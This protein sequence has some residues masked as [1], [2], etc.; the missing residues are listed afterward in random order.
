MEI[1]PINSEEWELVGR[2][3]LMKYFN[4]GGLSNGDTS[5]L[6]EG[7]NFINT[8]GYSLSLVPNVDLKNWTAD[9]FRLARDGCLYFYEGKN[10]E[11]IEHIVAKLQQEASGSREVFVTILPVSFFYSDSLFTLPLFRFKPSHDEKEEKFIDHTGRV[12]QNIEDWKMNNTL[13]AT[14][15]LYPRDGHLKLKPNEKNKLDVAFEDSAECNRPV[16]TLMACDIASGALGLAAGIGVTLATGGTA[17]LMMG[18]M[19]LSASYGVGRAGFRLRDRASH[20]ESI[21]PFKNRE[22]FWVWLG[23]GSE[24][25]TFGTIGLASTKI[26]SSITQSAAIVEITKR[27]AT[28]SRVMSV[29]SGAARPV[30]DSAKALLTGY[31]IFT[32]FRHK[33]TNAVL[34]LPKSALMQLSESIDEFN[35]TN[36]LMMSIT[37]GFWSKSKIMYVSPEEFQT[38][39]QATIINHMGDNCK[40]RKLFDELVAML[41]ND[42]ALIKTYKNLNENIDLNEMIQVIY[43]VFKANDDKLNIKLLGDTCHISL[44]NFLLHIKSLVNMTQEKIF[45]IIEFLKKF[46]HDQKA[47]FLTI[48]DYIGSNDDFLS[49]LAHDNANE[50]IEIWYDV[51]VICFDEHLTTIP[52]D[53]VIS[54]KN[55]EISIDILKCFNKEERLNLIFTIKNMSEAQNQNFK[56][57]VETDENN[58]LKYYKLLLEDNDFLRK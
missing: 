18:G 11:P 19:A 26:L 38:M 20:S 15:I 44:D 29:F 24:I 8:I 45:K 56:V 5:Q 12:Y 34:K 58:A 16:K 30:T 53:N 9:H 32:K 4:R 49:M 40:N 3:T 43:D 39:V 31:E 48:Q 17:L 52:K 23:L 1:E 22:A 13:P 6:L 37:E 50:L 51:F 7:A 14:K 35:E 54:L 57:L 10:L 21:N 36:M 27:F 41:Q 33:S 47:R 28:A 46:D 55:L 2:Q 25:S 42:E